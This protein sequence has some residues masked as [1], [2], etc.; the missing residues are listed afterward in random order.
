MSVVS[1][2]VHRTHSVIEAE[3]HLSVTHLDWKYEELSCGAQTF[4][5]TVWQTTQEVIYLLYLYVCGILIYKPINY[6]IIQR[7]PLVGIFTYS[8]FVAF[9]HSGLSLYWITFN[10]IYIS[11]SY[12]TN[13]CITTRQVLYSTHQMCVGVG[14]YQRLLIGRVRRKEIHT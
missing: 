2:H 12:Y 13:G 6:W 14:K 5:T 3:H 11:D 9:P 7:V 1:H 10:W 8:L 4:L